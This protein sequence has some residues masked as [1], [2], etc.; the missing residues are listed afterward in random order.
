M[1]EHMRCGL[2]GKVVINYPMIP[3]VMYEEAHIQCSACR[4]IARRLPVGNYC[5]MADEVYGEHEDEW[6][7]FAT[8]AEGG[9][10]WLKRREPPPAS[11]A[12]DPGAASTGTPP[13]RA[14]SSHSVTDLLDDSRQEERR[15]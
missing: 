8:H 1:C 2:C 9:I 11:D 4:E 5:F 13:A 14:N 3:G 12:I 10:G 7:D 15:S 6:E